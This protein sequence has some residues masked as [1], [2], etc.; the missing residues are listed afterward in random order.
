MV[1]AASLGR[2]LSPEET[3]HH[4]NGD[5]TDNRIENLQLMKTKSHGEGQ[6]WV[7]SDCGSHNIRSEEII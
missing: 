4:I 3:V 6:K 2:P 7:C 1:M 5:R